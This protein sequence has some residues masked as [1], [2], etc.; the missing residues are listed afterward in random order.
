MNMKLYEINNEIDKAIEEMMANVDEAT[1]EVRQEDLDKL[2]DLQLARGEKLENIGCYI[3]NLKAESKA[4]KDEAD[5][6]TK[7]KKSLDNQIKGLESYVSVML[8]G[9]PF[10]SARVKFSFIE[11]EAVIIDD[12]KKLARSWFRKKVTFEPNKV[13][14]KDAIKAGKK[15]RFAH[16][17]KK[18]NLQIN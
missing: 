5:A 18:K 3:K 1:G 2:N 11:S 9:E 14:I 15:V 17:E 7:R 16:I 6:L 4:I 12:D 10:E 8:K 13:A